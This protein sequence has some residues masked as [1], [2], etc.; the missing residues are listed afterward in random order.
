LENT[1]NGDTVFRS[2]NV[3]PKLRIDCGLTKKEPRL[4]LIDVNH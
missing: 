3:A 4:L 2:E 1:T